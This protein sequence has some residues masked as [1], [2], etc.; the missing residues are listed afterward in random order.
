M[1]LRNSLWLV[2]ALIATVVAVGCTG[3]EEAPAPD[4]SESAAAV[5]PAPADP[6]PGAE[7][8]DAPTESGSDI[9]Y[10]V[11]EIVTSLG[12]MELELYPDKAPKS[13]ENFLAY[14]RSGFFDGTIFHR[15]VPDFVI[16]GGGFDTEMTKKDT[17]PPIENEADNGLRNL[18][19]TICMARTNDPHSATSQFFINTTDNPNLDHRDKLRDWGYAVFGKI[20]VG[21]EVVDAI[22]AVA[23]TNRDGYQNVP[24]DPV[25]METARIKSPG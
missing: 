7:T 1:S 21:L 8:A 12:T 25:I 20:T 10:P 15:V 18:R 11:V 14:V 2:I 4:E 6:A 19:G 24:V 23:T 9:A 5:E 13:V 3:G 16:Q 22:E 17:E